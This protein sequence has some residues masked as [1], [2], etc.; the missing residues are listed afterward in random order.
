LYKYLAFTFFLIFFSNDSFSSLKKE[1]AFFDLSPLHNKEVK[2][3]SL[4]GKW[5][6]IWKKFVDPKDVL[7]EG[8]PNDVT[9]KKVP[10]RWIHYKEKFPKMGFGTYLAVLKNVPKNKI[11]K[12]KLE[13]ISSSYR[14]YF[15]QNNRI[16]DSFENGKVGSK[17]KE[18]SPGKRFFTKDIHSVG[19]DIVVIFHISNFYYRSGGFFTV[20]QIGDSSF[21]EEEIKKNLLG[22]HIISGLLLMMTVYHLALVFLRRSDRASLCFAS[23]CGLLFLR[24]ISTEGYMESFFEMGPFLYEFQKKIEFL[25]FAW[26]ATSL[27]LFLRS[28]LGKKFARVGLYISL[29]VSISFTPI[30]LIFKADLYSHN[31]ILSFF[32]VIFVILAFITFIELLIATFKK[33]K[34][35]S[36]IL[37]PL[38]FAFITLFYE[39]FAVK[40][41]LNF[42]HTS[43]FGFSVF[44]FSQ[45]YILARRFNLAYSTAERLTEHLQEE[46]EIQ[47]KEANDQSQRAQKSEK[48]IKRLL[49]NMKQAVFALGKGGKV[50]PP[51]SEFSSSIFGE[52]IEGSD[53][54]EVLFEEL[55]STS[56]VYHR[57]KFLIDVCIDEDSLQYETLHDYLPR[58]IRKKEGRPEEQI[59]RV[60]YSPIEDE[61]YIC[62]KILLVVE[63]VT[64]VLKLEKEV[65][66][67]KERASVKAL[68]LQEI[69]SNS[70][71]EIKVFFREAILQMDI[72]KRSANRGDIDSFFRVVHTLK[73]SSRIYNLS[74]LGE[75][76]HL[77]EG[78]IVEIRDLKD[79]K[80][81]PMSNAF[82]KLTFLINE[83]LDLFKEVYGKDIDETMMKI[84]DEFVEIPRDKFFPS[85]EK[86]KEI[87]KGL[88]SLE[89][90]KEIKKIEYEDLKVSLG[91]LQSSLNNMAVSMK[92]NLSLIIEGDEIYLSKKLSLLIKDSL[93]H[94]IQNSADH[95]IEK[96]GKIILKLKD[97]DEKIKIYISDNGKGIDAEEIHKKALKKGIVDADSFDSFTK[98]DKLSLILIPGFSTKE[99]ATEYSG[100]GV[101]M[102]VVKTNIEKLGGTIEIDSNIGKG[103][104]FYIT[105]PQSE[106]AS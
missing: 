72:A 97:I 82:E 85:I 102:D 20:P 9:L 42:R 5:F 68:R 67:E 59:L 106:K 17:R 55:D 62:R 71:K 2:K 7:K 61:H 76:I 22:K 29:I 93:M 25:T 23:F 78:N 28:I 81:L 69:V 58:E 26:S 11:Y 15:I 34:D 33:E 48:E 84:E 18:S 64:E 36:I 63:D 49:N 70:K 21:M 19:G 94:I 86:I 52:N 1:Q 60:S 65:K 35:A 88:N 105:I 32:K 53:I 30:I 31:Y 47:T 87:L 50:V 89:G 80:V 38:A 75:E 37:Y 24:G 99:Q 91:S 101:G 90:L 74:H 43:S 92:K 83:Y 100:R 77:L 98:K 46:V 45:S 66:L 14:V 56:E 16:I 103:T 13:R 12:I 3:I 104:S 4:K 27:V 10:G 79:D 57:V 44:L 96:E 54:F 8:I 39:I 6:F 73:G 41:N 40:N 95:G 51:V